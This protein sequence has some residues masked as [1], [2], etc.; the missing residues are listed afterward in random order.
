MQK[1]F[2]FLSLFF[3]LSL[4]LV[5][6]WATSVKAPDFLPSS[7]NWSF[8]VE[9]DSTDSFDKAIVF[10]DQKEL[11]SVFPN[12]QTVKDPFNGQFALTAF[13]VDSDPSSTQGL[14]LYVS[15]IG[16]EPGQHEIK[17]DTMQSGSVKSTERK[18]IEFFA[19]LR[20]DF[21]SR[22]DMSIDSII[23]VTDRLKERAEALE[24][25]M[26]QAQSKFGEVQSF[27]DEQVQA[28]ASMQEKLDGFVEE[29][30]AKLAEQADGISSLKAIVDPPKVEEPFPAENAA[31]AK[32]GFSLPQI[33]LPTLPTGLASLSRFPWIHIFLAL[34]V[35]GVLVFLFARKKSSGGSNGGSVEIDDRLFNDAEA[36]RDGRWSSD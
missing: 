22:F 2:K 30:N 27:K 36:E 29:S 24:N 25:S 13:T 28:L 16:I 8:S 15:V 3:V 19:P 35:V 21:A 7:V 20:E 5:P 4:V 9:L 11:V 17:V 33:G 12:G 14:V 26:A 10:F 23:G 6:A 1:I 31:E 32:P 18:S 34:V